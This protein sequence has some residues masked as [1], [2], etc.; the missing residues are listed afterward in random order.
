MDNNTPEPNNPSVTPQPD[1]PQPTVQQPQ[2]QVFVPT[3]GTD[4]VAA[5]GNSNAPQVIVGVQPSGSLATPTTN[6]TASPVPQPVPQN[7]YLQPQTGMSQSEIKA[8]AAKENKK[9]LFKKLLF[10]LP[11]SLILVAAIVAGLIFAK[12][13]VFSRFDTVSYNSKGYTYTFKWWKQGNI[14]TLQGVQF[15][16]YKTSAFTATLNALPF[17]N[18]Y[19]SCTQIPNSPYPQVF[20]VKMN[21][22]TDPVCTN[23]T[24][25]QYFMVFSALNRIHI[26]SIV[27]TPPPTQPTSVYPALKTIFSSIKVSQ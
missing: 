8:T 7:V 24:D 4:S 5:Q 15:Y 9:K 12:N 13:T 14:A 19:S 18:K 2:A 26:V 20:T 22:T 10:I 1:N 6:M 25:A 11:V 16:G 23:Q 27:F 17:S 21:G 3:V